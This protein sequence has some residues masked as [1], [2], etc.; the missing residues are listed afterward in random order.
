ML[1]DAPAPSEPAPPAVLDAV[2][3][4]MAPPPPP[5]PPPPRVRLGASAMVEHYALGA[6]LAGVD[7]GAAVWIVP[8][9]SVLLALRVRGGPAVA[10]P[11]GAISPSL[12]GGAL[13]AAF[14][15]TPTSARGGVDLQGKL[16]FA[17]V[18]FGAVA[19]EG[20]RALSQSAGTA[21]VELGVEGW[22]ALGR[23]VRLQLGVSWVQ[24]L[25]ALRALDGADEITGVGGP[26]V[27]GGLGA[28][29]VF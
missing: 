9:V 15:V 8:R 27:A 28:C 29:A 4:S 7:V 23:F 18:S 20:A 17:R 1:T 11:H 25:R 10:A 26:G 13:G 14:T 6:T 16:G 3:H 12:L 19:N 21:F 5:A 2:H 22:L 24:T